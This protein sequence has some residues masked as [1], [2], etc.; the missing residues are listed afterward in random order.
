MKCNKIIY[1]NFRNIE[2][3]SLSFSDGTNILIGENAEGKTSALEGIY[4]FAG[5]KSFRAKSEREM[6]KFGS[7]YAFVN[8]ECEDSNRRYQMKYAFN[9]L[10]KRS[11][12]RNGVTLKR[13][14]ELI[15]YF[16]AILFTPSQLSI[17]QSGPSARRSFIDVAIAQIKPGYIS[18]LQRYNQILGQR[19]ALIK[20]RQRGK[21]DKFEDTAEILSYQLAEYAEIIAN[22]RQRYVTGLD[23]VTNSFMNDMTLGKESCHLIYE[24]QKNKEQYFA[25]LTQNLEREIKYG[26]TLYGIHKDDIKILI[27]KRDAKAYASQGQ[28]RSAALSMHLG[29]GEISANAFSGEHPVYLFDDVL[30]ELDEKRRSYVISGFKNK[31][32]FITSCDQSALE[33][34]SGARI[35]RVR[36]GNYSLLS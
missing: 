10:G 3:A 25:E 23:G 36:N 32:V 11:C 29:E 14:S 21:N 35:F 6:I 16:R 15:G 2:N 20:A 34:I 5:A 8:L 18:Y 30:S 17:V 22:Y 1:G 9:S 26:A 13:L 19:N 4:L 24:E 12:Q 31:Q 7:E 33:G 27:C 28:M